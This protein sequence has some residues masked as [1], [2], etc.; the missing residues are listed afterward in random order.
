MNKGTIFITGI[1]SFVGSNLATYFSSHGY[2]VKGSVSDLSKASPLKKLWTEVTQIKL[3]Q[4]ISEDSIPN[5]VTVVIYAAHD[6]NIP[7]NNIES[8]KSIYKIAEKKGCQQ[9]IFISS[10]SASTDNQT[11]YGRVKLELETFFSQRKNGLVVRPGLVIGNGGLYLN[12]NSFV[13]A[14]RL[15]PLPDGGIYKMAIIEVDVLAECLKLLIQ[16]KSVGFYN[17]Y[18]T[19]L[20]T[21]REIVKNIAKSHHKRVI[22]INIPINITLLFFRF[23]KTILKIIKV[24]NK[25]SIDSVAGYKLYKNL[26]IPP[27]H[28]D[29][30]IKDNSS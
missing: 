13:K 3:G 1:N 2:M 22:I 17:L 8:N 11:D 29:N 7:A 25:F 16:N 12:M 19:Q 18:Q 5:D 4:S 10:L 6:K 9:H 14:N 30:L 27:S 24:E 20:I 28:L 21:L 26:K 15:V 23:F